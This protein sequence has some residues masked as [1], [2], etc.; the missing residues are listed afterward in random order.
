MRIGTQN[1][2]YDVYDRNIRVNYVND[3]VLCHD[4]LHYDAI[5]RA[6]VNAGLPLKNL[7]MLNMARNATQLSAKFQVAD[8]FQNILILA[9]PLPLTP[10]S[11][12]LQFSVSTK[13]PE[14]RIE[15]VILFKQVLKTVKL[16]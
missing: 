16:M 12:T 14:D 4:A 2:Q 9:T 8:S 15:N 1:G 11:K 13:E 7:T 6:M 10:M 3:G 5:N